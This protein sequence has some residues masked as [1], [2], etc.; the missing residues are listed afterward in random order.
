[1]TRGA[2][3]RGKDDPGR[4]ERFDRFNLS[5]YPPLNFEH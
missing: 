1:M 5:E 2:N 4:I 3:E